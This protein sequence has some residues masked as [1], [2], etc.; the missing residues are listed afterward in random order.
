MA[1]RL[2]TYALPLLLLLG[3]LHC[4]EGSPYLDQTAL[5]IVDDMTLD[6]YLSEE[7]DDFNDLDSRFTLADLSAASAPDTLGAASISPRS[8]YAIELGLDTTL[9]EGRVYALTFDI[10]CIINAV[11]AGETGVEGD[12]M[13]GSGVVTFT[14]ATIDESD[15]TLTAV[16]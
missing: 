16:Y 8:S 2:K 11:D 10:T 3:T 13:A 15:S 5:V 1:R 9:V 14:V 12:V 7:L 6:L 4:Q